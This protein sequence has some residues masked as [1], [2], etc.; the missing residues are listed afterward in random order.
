MKV[1]RNKPSLMVLVFV[2]TLFA[3]RVDAQTVKNS[4]ENQNTIFPKGEQGPAEYFTGTVW[5]QSLVNND[6]IYD[7]VSGSVTFEPGARAN[8][9]SHPSG[10]ILMVINGTGF[11]QIKGEPKQV[12]RKGD[13]VQ[14]PPN[15]AHWHGASPNSSMTHIHIVPNTERGIVEWMQPVTEEEYR[16]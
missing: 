3:L 2:L 16:K 5:V 1:I 6:S 10:Q 13:V 9:H 12:I 14:C 7:M 11:H 8:W 15:V 4:P